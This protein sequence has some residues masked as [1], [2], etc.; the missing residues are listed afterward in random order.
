MLGRWRELGQ[1]S[2]SGPP[3]RPGCLGSTEH[4]VYKHPGYLYPLGMKQKTNQ[5][6]A[7]GMEWPPFRPVTI[8]ET[9]QE[10]GHP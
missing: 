7:K 4:S 3:P 8:K 9:R 2:T 10:P 6:S 5:T 1:G